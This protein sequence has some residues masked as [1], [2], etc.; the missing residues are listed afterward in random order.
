MRAER[1]TG[2]RGRMGRNWSS[3]P[4]N[5]HISTLVR[6]RPTDPP[7]HTLALVCAV[8]AREAAQAFVS[9]ARVM[10][11]WPND[12]MIDGAKLCGMLLERK[13]EAVIAG[14]GMN[15]AHAPE[16]EGRETVSL[17]SC[18]AGGDMSVADVAAN[19][20][21]RFASWLAIWRNAGL[22]VVRDAWVAGA[23]DAGTSLRVVL[24]DGKQIEGRF[25]GLGADGALLLALADGG[26]RIVHAGD[27][28]TL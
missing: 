3:E 22:A 14:F 16:I 23:H 1:Q 17:A 26:H 24:P 10:I 4:G 9:D 7:A 11:K 25:E 6:L 20:S 27:V 12:L 28:F 2:G 13:G 21:E 5:L 8:A 19:L 18:A 15:V